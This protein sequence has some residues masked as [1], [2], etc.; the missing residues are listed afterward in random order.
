MGDRGQSG[1]VGV[2]QTCEGSSLRVTQLWEFVGGSGHGTV[3]LTD[4]QH[5]RRSFFDTCGIPV[6]GEQFRQSHGALVGIGDSFELGTVPLLKFGRPTLRELLKRCGID[7]PEES[8]G[9]DGEVIV[10]LLEAPPTDVGEGV[11]LG[12]SSPARAWHGAEGRTVAGHDIAGRLKGVEVLAYPRSGDPQPCG[13]FS[14][15]CGAVG[16]QTAHDPLFASQ[17]FHNS[18]VA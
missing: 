18:I 15:R 9:A 4:L 11:D 7:L 8:Q 13:Q 1:D 12:G 5:C 6:R 10:G 16:Q 14:G 17:T 3:V 2:Q